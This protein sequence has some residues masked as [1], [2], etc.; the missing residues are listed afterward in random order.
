MQL[1]NIMVV[2]FK[3]IIRQFKFLNY[4]ICGLYSNVY[5]LV[6]KFAMNF[7]LDKIFIKL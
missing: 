3:V 5:I 1:S 2:T 4:N 7:R 6:Y